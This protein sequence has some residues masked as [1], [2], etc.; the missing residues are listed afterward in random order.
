MTTRRSLPVLALLVAGAC[1]APA[2]RAEPRST[3]AWAPAPA[4]FGPLPIGAE[5]RAFTGEA[6]YPPPLEGAEQARREAKLDEALA[7][8]ERDPEDL[9]A[10][11][12]LG[13]RLAYL[14]RFR[15]ALDV[16]T[17]GLD[18]H[19]DEPRLL[20]HR[21]H[22]WITVRDFDRAVL[23]LERAADLVAGRPDEVEPDGI[24]N[25]RGIPLE[26]LQSNVH[27]H[28]ALARYLR[29]DFEGAVPAW[30]A[31]LAAAANPDNR[32]SA[33]HWLATT[34]RRL[35][36]E[37][38]AEEALEPITAELD[39]VEYHAYHQL[40]LAYRGER[41]LDQL[42][43]QARAAGAGSVEHASLG[44]GAGC[45][46][47]AHGRTERAR[48]IFREVAAS[49]QWHAFGRIASEVELARMR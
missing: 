5:A 17:L 41:D 30:R 28:L 1:S 8:W 13:R 12:W 48:E 45:W 32:C 34:L 31:A 36:R 4:S 11:I 44:Y 29:G 3:A 39:V 35:G 38:E 47:L 10:T 46:H 25:A 22:R 18:R 6:L 24:P 20:R 15:E 27:Y 40:C 23:D 19:P 33:T 26:T 49:P 16:Y 9:E 14:G 37:R 2:E 7:A 21:G 42:L 43:A